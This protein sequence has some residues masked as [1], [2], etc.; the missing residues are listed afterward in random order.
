LLGMPGLGPH[1]CFAHGGKPR[2]ES[3]V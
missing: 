3:E 1:S 2:M